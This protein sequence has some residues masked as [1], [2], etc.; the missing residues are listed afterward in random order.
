MPKIESTTHEISISEIVVGNRIR[1]ELGDISALATSIKTDGL[2]SPIIITREGK[3]LVAGYRRL[4][5][6][7]SLKLTS[8]PVRFFEDFTPYEILKLQLEEDILHKKLSWQEEVRIKN[9]LHQIYMERNIG[10]GKGAYRKGGG[11]DSW[12]QQSTAKELNVNSST[13]SEEL[14]LAQATKLFPELLK[15][16]TKTDAI[17]K[18]YR[19]QEIAVLQEIARRRGSIEGSD[20]DV[21]LLNGDCTELIKKIPDESI[22]LIITDPPWGINLEGLAGVGTLRRDS[23]RFDDSTTRALQ[24][25]RRIAPELFRVLK[26]GCHLYIFFGSQLYTPVSDM[27]RTAGFD[28]SFIPLIWVKDRPGYTAWEYK[29]MPQYEPFFFAVKNT[30]QSPRR[31]TEGTSDVFNYPRPGTASSGDERYHITEKP[32]TLLKRLISLSSNPGEVILDPFAGSASTLIAAMLSRRRA[33]G[34]E[35]DTETWKTAL[36][37]VQKLQVELV[38]SEDDDASAS[39]AAVTTN[40]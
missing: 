5:A 4:K 6:V 36:G 16:R 27:L 14:R 37:R 9:E 7:E 8:I 12:T 18:M 19:L 29:P 20:D 33:I 28:I 1:E 23:Q 38:V 40:S 10:G 2:R 15:I 22:D 3:R 17:R 26:E 39:S 25:Y 13:L 11:K 24:L 32:V 30:K 21:R 35:L 31:F 34:I